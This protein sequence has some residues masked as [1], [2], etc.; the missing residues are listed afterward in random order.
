MGYGSFVPAYL[1]LRIVLYSN[2]QREICA[3]GEGDL[4]VLD[5]AIF[6]LIGPSVRSVPGIFSEPRHTAVLDSIIDVCGT[7]AHA[8]MDHFSTSRSGATGTFG[9]P[10]R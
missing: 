5:L 10:V 8:C 9:F 7:D 4:I 2:F 6:V 1:N 3:C